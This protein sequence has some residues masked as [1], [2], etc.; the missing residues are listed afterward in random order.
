MPSTEAAR[1]PRSA[2]EQLLFY[3]KPEVLNAERHGTL[4]L[5]REGDFAFAR[6]SNA[7]AITSTE[8][9]QAMRCYPIV[10]AGKTP[11]PVVVLGLSRENLFVGADGR[12]RAGHYIPAYMRRYPFVFI[13]HPDGKQFMLGIDRACTRLTEDKVDGQALFEEGKPGAI[14]QEALTFCSAFQTDHGFTQAF[15]QALE[16]QQLLTE[17]HAQAKLA[18][19]R[20]MNLQG[21][22]V[23]DRAKF[24]NLSDDVI[25]DWHRKGWLALANFHLASLE[26]FQQLVEFQ[27]AAK[28]NEQ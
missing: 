11:Y 15:A 28:P 1:A 19:G 8:F 7:V 3:R 21:F 20:Q 5:K 18:D 2:A 22:R 25:I 6:A 4:G 26:R 14:T 10:F 12:W 24:A 17:N 16:A 27:A 23:I 9:V 13:A